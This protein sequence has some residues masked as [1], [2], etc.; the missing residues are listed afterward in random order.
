MSHITAPNSRG[1]RGA[2]L[3]AAIALLSPVGFLLAAIFFGASLTPSL[4]PRDPL[5][6]GALGGVVAIVG[7]GIGLVAKLLWQYMQLPIPPLRTRAGLGVVSFVVSLGIGVYCLWRAADWQN[8]TRLVLEMEPVPSSHP[9]TIAGVALAVF[10]LLGLICLGFAFVV[11]RVVRFMDR[12]LPPRIGRVLGVV[13]VG[14][15]FWALIDGFLIQQGLTIADRAFEAADALIDPDQPRPEEPLRTGSAA[16]LVRWDEMGRWGRS[17]VATAPKQA[18]I[19]AFSGPGAMDPIRVYVGRR[20][21]ETARERAR[22]ALEELIRVGGFERKALVVADPVGTGW[23]DPGAQ[24]TL[25]Y[26]M[27]GDVATVAVQYSYLTSVLSLYVHPDDGIEQSRELFNAVYEY[28]TRLPKDKRPKLYV[29][30]L[31]QGAFNSQMTLPLLDMLADPINGGMWAGSPFFS[32]FWN[33]VREDR[34]PGSPAWQPRYGN[35]S[36]VRAMNQFGGVPDARAKAPWGPIRFVF[37]NYGSDPLVVFNA[38]AAIQPPDWMT[39]P[40]APDVSKELRWFPIVTSFQLAMDMAISLKV[41]R[42]GHYYVAQ[43]YIDAW[44]ATLDPEGW[45]PGR[46]AALK[47]FFGPHESRFISDS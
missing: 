40:R 29:H 44:V 18:E 33:R 14:W 16:S 17:F 26:I 45:S 20:S 28:W 8:A 11:R 1:T 9:F 24:D 12:V 6:Q 10:A 27:G 5:A 31:S 32:P 37:L 39:E 38:A 41:P 42:F 23:M 34:V 22:L 7:Y 35:D 21:A 43:D 46:S 25:D 19:A 15:V 13:L 30:G 2:S 47:K 3:A 36:L 4:I